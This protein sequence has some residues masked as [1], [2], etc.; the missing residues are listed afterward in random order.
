MDYTKQELRPLIYKDREDIDEFDISN[1][2]SLD[3]EM[4]RQIEVSEL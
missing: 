4:L 2:Q 3:A 1:T